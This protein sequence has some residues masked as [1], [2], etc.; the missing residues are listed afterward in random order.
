MLK[1]KWI[2][3]DKF[4]DKWT[5][6]A[7]WYNIMPVDLTQGDIVEGQHK[8]IWCDRD[9]G[10]GTYTDNE[11]HPIGERFIQSNTSEA[12]VEMASNR[13]SYTNTPIRQLSVFGR[14]FGEYNILVDER[15]APFQISRGDTI[16]LRRDVQDFVDGVP[17]FHI[18][19][20]LTTRRKSRDFPKSKRDFGDCDR[21]IVLG[22]DAI[23]LRFDTNKHLL[24][25]SKKFGYIS[26][27]IA[28]TAPEFA[29]RLNDTILFER[30]YDS[31]LNRDCY[32]FLSNVT[33]D[34][35]RTEFLLNQR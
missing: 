12:V 30:Y 28:E 8:Y 20:N 4:V 1:N 3:T 23:D 16:L 7:Y 15:A 10:I 14:R 31:K 9:I 11:L 22:I 35:L 25:Y 5:P 26:S 34:K 33:I 32:K 27:S 6:G 18:L 24:V 29:S 2:I 13:A 19:Y 17:Q 21:T